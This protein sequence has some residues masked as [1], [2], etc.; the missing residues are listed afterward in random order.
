MTTLV[1]NGIFRQWE[2]YLKAQNNKR[3]SSAC[4]LK[5]LPFSKQ[6]E[7]VA[8][9]SMKFL[10]SDVLIMI[11][12]VEV[13]TQLN[14]LSSP[15]QLPLGTISKEIWNVKPALNDSLLK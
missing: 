3:L 2:D 14:L 10:W 1:F 8:A 15:P 9:M 7:S 12:H 13:W 4:D 11:L 5:G 6:G